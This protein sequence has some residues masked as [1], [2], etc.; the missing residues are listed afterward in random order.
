[1]FFL[2]KKKIVLHFYTNSPVYS[3]YAP[4][5]KANNFFPEWWKNLPKTYQEGDIEAST[6]KG[7]VGFTDLYSKGFILPMWSSVKI[8]VGEIGNPAWHYQ[9]KDKSSNAGVHSPTQRGS[10]LP[11]SQYQHLKLVAPWMVHC[12]EDVEFMFVEPTYNME[13]LNSFKVLPGVVNFKYQSSINVNLM[14]PR[15]SEPHEIEIPFLQP[16]VHIVPVSNREVDV[17]VL[18]DEE[19][20]KY[21]S[22]LS[23]LL[24]LHNY[25]TRKKI[26]KEKEKKRCPFNFGE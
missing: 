3:E 16:M 18:Y 10:Y 7:C 23:K 12:D 4:P 17:K 9:Y 14:I 8:S 15:K 25:R 13:E 26:I 24:T 5:E 20:Y 11:E 19:K 1:M 6:M 22:E 21:Y 2:P